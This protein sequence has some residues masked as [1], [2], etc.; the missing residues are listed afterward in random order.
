MNE[1]GAG[2]IRLLD[3][4]IRAQNPG[5]LHRCQTELGGATMA[6]AGAGF[7]EKKARRGRRLGVGPT[8]QRAKAGTRARKLGFAWS[9]AGTDARLGRFVGH[10][11]EEK[12]GP[13]R[14]GP[15]L[16]MRF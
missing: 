16:N 4:V 13:E 2:E 5:R 14:F 7:A 12:I 11:R 15:N 6:G 1:T 9:W 3:G 8:R 10:A